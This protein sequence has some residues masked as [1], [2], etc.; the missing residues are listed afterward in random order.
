MVFPYLR[1]RNELKQQR[2]LTLRTLY[3]KMGSD[4][5]GMDFISEG[6][7]SLCC[8]IDGVSTRV[9]VLPVSSCPR[10]HQDEDAVEAIKEKRVT[11]IVA[12]SSIIPDVAKMIVDLESIQPACDSSG[13]LGIH[14]QHLHQPK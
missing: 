12:E 6:T 14:F 4:Y 11:A 3:F 2:K 5:R 10:D 8:N 1:K 13:K 9:N 7:A